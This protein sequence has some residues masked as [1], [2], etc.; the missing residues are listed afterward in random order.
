MPNQVDKTKFREVIK[1]SVVQ[2]YIAAASW[3]L[4]ALLCPMYKP[5]HFIVIILITVAELL[6]IGRLAAPKVEYVPIPYTPPRSGNSEVDS[7]I[8]VGAGYIRRFDKI[9][10]ELSAID[11]G[12]AAK[13]YRIRELMNTIFEYISKNPDKLPRIR[14]F[15]NCYLPTLEKFMNTYIELSAQKIKGENITKTLK[16]IEEILDTVEPAFERQL[17]NLYEDKA[18]DITADITVLESLLDDEGLS[19]DYENKQ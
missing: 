10:T 8:E 19:L 9:S 4:F 16:G 15:M 18:I 13:L 11:T 1:K 5:A 7:V 2:Y 14:R 3:L 6:I 12:V 17:D